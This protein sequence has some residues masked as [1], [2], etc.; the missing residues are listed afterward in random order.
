[1]DLW[2]IGSCQIE[3]VSETQVPEEQSVKDLVCSVTSSRE[4]TVCVLCVWD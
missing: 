2:H 3:L 4:N 1:M